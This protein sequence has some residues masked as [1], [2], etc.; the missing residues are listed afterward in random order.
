M[1]LWNLTKFNAFKVCQRL[2]RAKG[3]RGYLKSFDKLFFFDKEYVGEYL[4]KPK[5]TTV[6]GCHYYHWLESFL[7][8]H[9]R[10]GEK[11][12]EFVKFECQSKT[13]EVMCD[14]CDGK[15]WIG[16][17]VQYVPAP[18]PDESKLPEFHYLHVRDTPLEYNGSSERWVTPT[19]CANKESTSRWDPVSSKRRKFQ[20]I[21]Q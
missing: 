19:T 6:P 5:N 10:K 8:N 16:S 1:I 14:F 4:S 20:P 7:E 15:D 12:I 17:H 13:E 11:C 18:M 21:S 9:C 3:Q 2:N